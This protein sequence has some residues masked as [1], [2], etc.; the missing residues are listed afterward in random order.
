MG[1]TVLITGGCGFLGQHLVRTIFDAHPDTKVVLMDKRVM[2]DQ[3]TSAMDPRIQVLP[4]KDITNF[5]EIVPHFENVDC[6]VHLAGLV[7]FSLRDK[8]A[9]MKINAEGTRNVLQAA[10]VHGVPKVVHISSVA[11][12]GYR[13]DQHDWV[14]ED[15]QFD[16]EIAEKKHKYYML[17]KRKA[18]DVVSEYRGNGQNCTILYPGLMFG[19]GDYSNAPKL[20]RA[21]A[22]GNIPFAMPGGT[23]IVDARDVA[24]GILLA[25]ASGIE[26][27]DILLSGYNLK[28]TEVN[29]IIASQLNIRAPKMM[30]GMSLNGFLYRAALLAEKMTSRKLELTADNIDS[31]F[32]FRYFDNTRAKELLGWQPE[33]TFEQMISDTIEWMREN[34][35]FEG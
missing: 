18:D 5:G 24:R 4:G 15:F 10:K 17:S 13:D 31:A 34:G 7:S 25:M 33:I 2:L 35:L 22:K 26:N 6:V 29:Q 8:D 12:L 9:L 23:N 1:E 27:A 11:A 21:I 20:I 16:W 19:P 30:L 32:K 3:I 14:N 28:F